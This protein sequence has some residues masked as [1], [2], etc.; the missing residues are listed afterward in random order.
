[1]GQFVILKSWQFRVCIEPGNPLDVEH[2]EPGLYRCVIGMIESSAI[3]RDMASRFGWLIPN[4]RSAITAEDTPALI[5]G[6]I[7]L[8]ITLEDLEGRRHDVE[9]WKGGRP[10]HAPALATMAP[11]GIEDASRRHRIA[12]LAAQTA[13]L[14]NIRIAH[15]HRLL[16][17]IE[18]NGDLTLLN[19]P[20][21]STPAVLPAET[22]FTRQ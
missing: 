5:G 14:Q 20:F 16:R 11:S 17:Q 15:R 7:A 10:C 3:D 4:R 9:E 6:T 2:V 22:V 13:T 12:D 18:W 19:V 21:G 1:M 8:G